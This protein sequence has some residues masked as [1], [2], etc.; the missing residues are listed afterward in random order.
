MPNNSL[1]LLVRPPEFDM[2]GTLRAAAAIRQAETGQQLADLRLR[3]AG[4]LHGAL[5]EHARTGSLDALK[6]HPEAY[7]SVLQ[8]QATS[9]TMQAANE[10]RN[11]EK[12]ARDAQYILS[13]PEA[14]RASAY[15]ERLDMAHSEGRVP[16]LVYQRMKSMGPSPEV[17]Q[18]IIDQALPLAAKPTDLQKVSAEETLGRTVRDPT[19]EG[20]MRF[21]PLVT[22]RP[23]INPDY[24]PDPDKPGRLRAKP[25]GAAD[26]VTG[27]Q[28]AR[29]ALMV[30]G[31]KDMPKI[32]EA[33]GVRVVSDPSAQGG[34]RIEQ[35]PSA[36]DPANAPLAPAYD[37]SGYLQ[38][39]SGP[40]KVGE[41]QRLMYSAMEGILRAQ[42]GAAATPTE[43]N[44]EL[45]KY[46]PKPSDSLATRAQKL[47]MFERNLRAIA[48]LNA[49]GVS[50]ADL[51]DMMREGKLAVDKP[52]TARLPKTP[53]DRQR[54]I[55]EAQDAVNRG[56]ARDAVI[57]ELRETHGIEVQ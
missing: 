29:V 24:E 8:N 6:A 16:A 44:R 33:F 55:T 17:L 37:P 28:A 57:K 56:A 15:H 41:G 54:L 27:E 38:H 50:G 5:Q 7:G 10:A 34:R 18:N 25:G 43:V 26:K 23:K 22:G 35:M 13:L 53:E 9:A 3:Q 14:D 21:V 12:N 52:H 46:L 32:R 47:D 20:G 42:T 31:V 2:A 36:R 51:V 40:G 4:D 49:H 39:W 30:E 11:K 45:E 1:A 19:A 48:T